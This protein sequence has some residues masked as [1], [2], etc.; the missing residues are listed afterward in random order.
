MEDFYLLLFNVLSNIFYA[1]GE[2]GV[3]FCLIGIK[4]PDHEDFFVEVWVFL[5]L[6]TEIQ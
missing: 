6:I 2:E 5:C 3:N 4:L 1:E